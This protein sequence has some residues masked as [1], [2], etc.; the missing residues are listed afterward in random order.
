MSTAA[1]RAAAAARSD[2]PAWG[3]SLLAAPLGVVA[4]G[5]A[6]G[7]L[8]G[9]VIAMTQVAGAGPV[10]DGVFDA[11]A[12]LSASALVPLAVAVGVDAACRREAF[13]L[14]T[15]CR[16]TWG[17]TLVTALLAPSAAIGV[18]WWRTG[19]IVWV[20][21]FTT[22]VLRWRSAP[23]AGAPRRFPMR[24]PAVVCASVVA[25]PGVTA[26][27]A[28]AFQ[29]ATPALRFAPV[30]GAP[31]S[32]LEVVGP[33][34]AVE[35]HLANR[36]LADVTIVGIDGPLGRSARLQRERG[37]ASPPPPVRRGQTVGM[38]LVLDLPACR[39]EVS[40]TGLPVRYRVLGLE[41]TSYL[42]LPRPLVA[43]C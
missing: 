22:V 17:A 2:R 18:G 15:G 20:L 29:I 34:A 13:W 7:V 37:G 3:S 31:Q 33:R 36:V 6:S 10:P 26:A 43:R 14:I 5:L 4:G 39:G 42:A 23:V 41:R 28:V 16:P 11:L 40:A 30:L 27:G 32:P 25:A 12:P 8:I 35:V 38:W 21:A 9:V 19:V 1:P 24:R